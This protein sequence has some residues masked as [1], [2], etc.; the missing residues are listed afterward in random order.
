MVA[1]IIISHHCH[2]GLILMFKVDS[3][4]YSD[5]IGQ[6]GVRF[7]IHDNNQLPFPHEN[8]LFIDP[9]YIT[10]ISLTVVKAIAN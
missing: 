2:T 6:L 1:S 10:T 9:G 3:S 7:L 5:I 4:D 8:G